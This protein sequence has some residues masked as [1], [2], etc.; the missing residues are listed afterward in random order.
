MNFFHEHLTTTQKGVIGIAAPIGSAVMSIVPHI[1]MG[2]RIAGLVVGLA[3]GVTA[4]IST[5]YDIRDKR[6]KRDEE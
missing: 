3:V 5:L 2:L 1:E 6:R 4:L